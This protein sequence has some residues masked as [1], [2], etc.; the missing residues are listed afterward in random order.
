MTNISRKIVTSVL[1]TESKLALWKYKPRIIAVTG[2]AGKTSTK[3]AVYAVMSKFVFVRKNAKSYNTQIGLPLTILGRP[4]QWNSPIGWIKNFFAGLWLSVWS[5]RY[6][7]WLVLEA[8]VGKPG[9]MKETA[10]WLKTDAVIVTAIGETPSHIEFFES[11]KHLIEEKSGLIKTLKKD[12]ILLLNFDDEAVMGMGEKAKTRIITFGFKEG[13]N[14]RGSSASIAY[15]PSGIPEGIIFRVDHNG[16]SIPVVIDGVFGKN[17]TYA[18]LAALALAS[19]LGFNLLEAA[20]ALKVYDLPPGR[21][22]L[23]QGI[24]GTLIIDDT[25]N[26]SPFACEAALDTLGEVKISGRKIAILG[27][28]L[29]LGKHT[30]DAHR[31]I[32]RIAKTNLRAKD[33]L[34]TV[35]PRARLIHEGAVAAGIKPANTYEFTNAREVGEFIKGFLK[36]GDMILV[37]GSQGMRMERIVAGIMLDQKN[38]EKLLV[39]QGSR[40][41]EKE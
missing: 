12:G 7:K 8:G 18:A 31:S 27:D 21:M 16:I 15:D 4:N 26:S 1:R 3:D 6:P 40:W 5:K 2:S 24:D 35:G 25:Y 22:R 14:L 41:A 32:G 23:L 34:I 17:H 9:D 11:R 38:K 30:E 10:E 36:K 29:E 13:A 39:R 33:V 19:E 37:K 20:N 28:M